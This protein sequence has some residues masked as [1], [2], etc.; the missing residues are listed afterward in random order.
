MAELKTRPTGN[1]VQEF[2]KNVDNENRQQDSFKILEMM[3]EITGEDGKMWGSS[4]VG[5][6]HYQYKYSSGRKGDWFLTG[7][8]PRKQNLTIYLMSGFDEMEDVMLNLGKF[9]TGKG[10]L[11]INKIEDIKIDVLKNLIET[12]IRNLKKDNTQT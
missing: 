4:I 11:Y 10:C 7:F 8:S 3:R 6:G 9:K 2:L 5:F 1:D 12:S